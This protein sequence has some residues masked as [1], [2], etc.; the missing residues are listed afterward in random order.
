M[1]YHYFSKWNWRQ[2]LSRPAQSNHWKSGSHFPAYI[3][4][5]RSTKLRLLIH[6]IVKKDFVQLLLA[7]LGCYFML[8]RE[9]A[10]RNLFYVRFNE[11]QISNYASSRPPSAFSIC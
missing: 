11:I 6:A 7:C 2:T 1:F 8:D 4:I 3:D 5:T 9:T 10:E